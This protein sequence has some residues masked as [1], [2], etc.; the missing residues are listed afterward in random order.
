MENKIVGLENLKLGSILAEDILANTVYPIAYVNTKV[1]REMLFALKA[2]NIHKVSIKKGSLEDDLKK[3]E[4]NKPIA[5]K[6]ESFEILLTENIMKFKVEF[7]NWEA[8]AKVDIA[9]VRDIILPLVDEMLSDRTRIF[10]LNEYVESTEYIYTHSIAVALITA[11][12]ANKLNYNKG[13]VLQLATAALLAD[14]GMSKISKKIRMKTSAL[15]ESEYKEIMTHPTQSLKMVKDIQL[16]KPEMK[17]AIFQHHEKLDGSGYPSG[18]EGEKISQA[19]HIIAI[20]DIFHAM[21]SDR[22]YKTKESVFKVVELIREEAFE[23]YRLDVTQALL[24]SVG[25]ISIGTI[26]ELSNSL[27]G[28]I[29]YINKNSITRPVVK[30][31]HN[32]ELIDLNKK[33]D[34]HIHRVY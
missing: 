29:V 11:V 22:L 9:K 30:L 2:F 3:E 31:E 21:T 15:T 13:D 33:R 6:K 5:K 19:A 14:C 34:L 17:I 27:V 1:D 24:S 10:S 26:V 25:D 12:I 28:K 32:G 7:T 18:T 16:L 8:G 23:K 20:A 4:V